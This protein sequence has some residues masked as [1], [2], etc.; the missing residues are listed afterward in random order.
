MKFKSSNNKRQFRNL[1]NIPINK[2]AFEFA[3]CYPTKHLFILVPTPLWNLIC[4]NILHWYKFAQIF[5]SGTN[6]H[7]IW[8][9]FSEQHQQQKRAPYLY[10]KICN[11]TNL[12]LNWLH[13][14]PLNYVNVIVLTLNSPFKKKEVEDKKEEYL[15]PSFMCDNIFNSI[16]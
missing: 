6:L 1:K 7:H 9:E 16:F 3:V 4:T 15:G 12:N 2:S 13:F 14:S 8:D 10:L 11:H 5:C